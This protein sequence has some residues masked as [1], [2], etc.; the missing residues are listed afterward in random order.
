MRGDGFGAFPVHCVGGQ[1]GGDEGAAGLLPAVEGGGVVGGGEAAE[2]GGLGEGDGGW[3][4]HDGLGA[5]LGALGL[6]IVGLG[7]MRLSSGVV[8]CLGSVETTGTYR[9][10]SML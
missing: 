3:G 1:V 5:G 10:C 2:V 8:V 9:C 7:Q 6:R 4:C